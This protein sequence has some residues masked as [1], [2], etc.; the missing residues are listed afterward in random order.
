MLYQMS[1]L[2]WHHVCKSGRALYRPPDLMQNSTSCLFHMA[3]MPLLRRS[4]TFALERSEDLQAGSENRR[5]SF[6]G[7]FR[8]LY[9][10]CTW[11]PKLQSNYFY[12]INTKRYSNSFCYS[13]HSL[14]IPGPCA[15]KTHLSSTVFGHALFLK[16]GPHI[17]VSLF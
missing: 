16:Y 13:W 14:V 12:S 15:N 10:L 9:T 7:G 5:V 4:W 17:P 1:K 3:E 11:A 2:G 8:A 6:G